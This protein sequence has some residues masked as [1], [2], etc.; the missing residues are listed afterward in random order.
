MTTPIFLGF[1]VWTLT[2]DPVWMPLACLFFA[3]LLVLTPRFKGV[4]NTPKIT[5]FLHVFWLAALAVVATPAAVAC[6]VWQAGKLVSE[7]AKTAIVWR[8]APA[9]L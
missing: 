5:E 8:T 7:V 6:F 1:F 4:D 9:V 2:I 3:G